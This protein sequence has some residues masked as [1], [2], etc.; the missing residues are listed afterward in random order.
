[1]TSKRISYKTYP[2]EFKLEAARM[3]EASGRSASEIA[4][5]LREVESQVLNS[6]YNLVKLISM[7]LRFKTCPP[8]GSFLS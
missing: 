7:N 8:L 4:A 5:E 3:M 6:E 2:K 1:M